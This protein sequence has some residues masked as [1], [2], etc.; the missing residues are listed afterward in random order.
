MDDPSYDKII[1]PDIPNGCEIIDDG[2]FDDIRKFG[3]G[4]F[5]MKSKVNVDY[6]NNKIQVLSVPMNTDLQQIKDKIIA[7]GK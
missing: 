5:R 1:Y 6:E 2:Q 4:K 7:M 3:V